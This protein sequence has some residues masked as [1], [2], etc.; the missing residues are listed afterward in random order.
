MQCGEGES[1]TAF[2]GGVRVLRAGAPELRLN[3]AGL[4][5]LTAMHATMA[6]MGYSPEEAWEEG[7]GMEKMEEEEEGG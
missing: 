3:V 7:E 1:C 4:N 5:P 6:E 2:V